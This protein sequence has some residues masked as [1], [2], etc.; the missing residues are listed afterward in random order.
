MEIKTIG[1]EVREL[2]T[3]ATYIGCGASKEAYKKEDIVYK[4]PRGRYLIEDSKIKFAIP[5]TI[6]GVDD[7]LEEI[8]SWEEK[9]VWPIGQFAIELIT[10]K[11]IKEAEKEGIDI[12]C[13]VPIVDYYYDRKNVLVIEQK[14]AEDCDCIDRNEFETLWSN[15]KKKINKLNGY[16]L[17]NYNIELRDIREGNCGFYNGE[18]ALFDFGISTTTSLDNY[19]S[20]SCYMDYDYEEEEEDYSY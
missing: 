16:L 18:I 6:E 15:F 1:E 12:G 11:A 8:E 7:L 20:Y 2:L 5:D 14:L 9:M 4:V 19:G 13:I 17:K 10:W 3:G